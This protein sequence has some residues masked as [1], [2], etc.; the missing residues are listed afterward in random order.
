MQDFGYYSQII[1][2][3]EKVNATQEAN[4]DAAASRMADAIADELMRFFNAP[5]EGGRGFSIPADD[6]SSRPAFVYLNSAR[7]E[8]AKLENARFRVPL[9]LAWEI[10]ET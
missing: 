9:S 5:D 7:R 1:A 2:N 3:L 6:A 10:H 4:I 8:P